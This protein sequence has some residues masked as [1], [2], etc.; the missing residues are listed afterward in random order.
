M[1]NDKHKVGFFKGILL[2]YVLNRIARKE[3]DKSTIR[4]LVDY[5]SDYFKDRDEKK[6]LQSIMR[7]LEVSKE[8]IKER[9]WEIEGVPVDRKQE[10]FAE[11]GRKNIRNQRNR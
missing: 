4:G 2:V 11:S 1:K 7:I 3:I 8:T 6:I 9:I 5:V 10:I